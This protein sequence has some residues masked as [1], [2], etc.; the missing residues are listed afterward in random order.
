MFL[1]H[2]S[3][4]TSSFSPFL[5]LRLFTSPSS[6]TWSA[7]SPCLTCHSLSIIAH[8]VCKVMLLTSQSTRAPAYAQDMLTCMYKIV[9][10]YSLLNIFDELYD[11]SLAENL[12][13]QHIF[14][15]CLGDNAYVTYVLVYEFAP[16]GVYLLTQIYHC[17][18]DIILSRTWTLQLS[19]NRSCSKHN[20]FTIPFITNWIL[21][22]L[23]LRQRKCLH[24]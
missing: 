13:C 2:P 7:P 5:H 14:G 3:I 9:H 20:Y 1:Q 11:T 24:F 16:S 8:S 18:P 19:I 6:S 10:H 21:F 23:H 12:S 17:Q 15:F 22:T 4:Y